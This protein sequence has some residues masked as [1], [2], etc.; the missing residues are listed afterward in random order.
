MVVIPKIIRSDCAS[1]YTSQLTTTFLKMLSCS[2]NFNVLGRPQQTGLCEHLIGT[3]KSMISKVAVDNPKRWYRHL[4]FV[5]WAIREVP[6]ATVGLPP[7][8]L[9]WGK[10]P[11]GQLAVLKDTMTGDFEMPLNLGK[12][13]TE[14]L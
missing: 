14:Y 4:G 6:H 12:S 2:P 3:L 9:T 11:R 5:L 8:L 1:N 13:A 7:W 10:L